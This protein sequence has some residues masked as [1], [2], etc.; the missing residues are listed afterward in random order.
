MENFLKQ[1]EKVIKTDNLEGKYC[2]IIIV[3]SSIKYI[4]KTIEDFSDKV[5]NDIKDIDKMFSIDF[6]LWIYD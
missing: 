1:A 5:E 4:Y 6:Q 3:D 2:I